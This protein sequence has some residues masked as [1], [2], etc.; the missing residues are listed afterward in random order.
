MI[1]EELR[2]GEEGHSL[3]NYN[4]S[5]NPWVHLPKQLAVK[6]F[7]PELIPELHSLNKLHQLSEE[8][9]QGGYRTWEGS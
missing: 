5:W 9:S 8:D 4:Q 1:Q 2:H 7:V 3:K 6:A